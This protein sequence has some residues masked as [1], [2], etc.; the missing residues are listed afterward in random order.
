MRTHQPLDERFIEVGHGIYVRKSWTLE[1][2]TAEA[3]TR[4]G[5]KVYERFMDQIYVPAAL[6]ELDASQIQVLNRLRRDLMRDDNAR[7]TNTAV[8]RMFAE[9]VD[10]FDPG[11]MVEWGCGYES[12]ASYTRAKE[13]L[14]TDIDPEVVSYQASRGIQCVSRDILVKSAEP[15]TIDLIAAVFVF[16]FNISH[17]DIGCMFDLLDPNGVIV[18]NVYKRSAPARERLAKAF[19]SHDFVVSRHDDPKRL[20]S[21]HEYWIISKGSPAALVNALARRLA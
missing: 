7:R 13:F 16:H 14:A 11:R 20:C 8:K 4:I 17:A 15:R 18:A 21:N 3:T 10:A 19:I 12:L 1:T 9:L 2:G 5:G 6:D